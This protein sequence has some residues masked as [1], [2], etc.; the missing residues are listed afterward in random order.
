MTEDRRVFTRVPF[1]IQASIEGLGEV[2][3][4]EVSDLSMRG[5]FVHTEEAAAMDEE[6]EI[7]LRM[8]GTNPPLVFR[9][10]GV[11]VR[12]VPGGI[13]F[14]ICESDLQSFTHLRNIVAMQVEDPDQV[15]E[16]LFNGIE[17]R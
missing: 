7:T 10:R 15:L 14:K 8:A 17:P 1:H 13:G 16:E 2:I 5:L 6:A 3:E 9:V 4:G 11:V 12:I